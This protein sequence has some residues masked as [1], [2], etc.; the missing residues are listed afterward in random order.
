MLVLLVAHVILCI[1]VALLARNTRLGFWG[2][3]VL[4]LPFPPWGPLL[5]LAVLILCSSKSPRRLPKT[6]G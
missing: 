6:E 4:S 3:L 5:V 2:I 1:I